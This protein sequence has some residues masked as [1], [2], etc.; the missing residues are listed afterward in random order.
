VTYKHDLVVVS[1]VK[2]FHLLVQEQVHGVRVRGL[3]RGVVLVVAALVVVAD[4]AWNLHVGLN[5]VVGVAT[6]SHDQ[7][8]I[9]IIRI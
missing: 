2:D 4:L 5:L 8:T 3:S 7:E 6:S 9:I 1:L